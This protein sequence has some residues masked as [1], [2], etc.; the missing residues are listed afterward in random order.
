MHMPKHRRYLRGWLLLVL[1]W[2][3]ACTG[4]QESIDSPQHYFDKTETDL[5]YG[6]PE[7]ASSFHRPRGVQRYGHDETEVDLAGPRPPQAPPESLTSPVPSR[8]APPPAAPL[9]DGG[10]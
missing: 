10:R 4:V 7:A 3:S 8:S 2:G 9:P 1:L 6:R 5:E